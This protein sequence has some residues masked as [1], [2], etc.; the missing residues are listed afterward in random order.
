MIHGSNDTLVP[1]SEAR[2]FVSALRGVSV[3]GCLYAELPR[4]QHAFDVL[5]SARPA[6]V[7]GG[8][9]RFLEAGQ[10][11]VAGTGVVWDRSRWNR[12]RGTADGGNMGTKDRPDVP[13]HSG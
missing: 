8:I 7:I 12:N 2:R 9:V 4:T 1:V 6:L 10:A 3:G 5:A 13:S 11:R